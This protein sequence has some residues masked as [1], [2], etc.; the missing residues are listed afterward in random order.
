MAKR[1]LAWPVALPL[2]VLSALAGHSAGYRV[3]VPDA[4]ERQHLLE[5]TGHGYLAYA[6]AAVGVTL[7]LA[8]LGF[9]AIVVAAVRQ[10]RDR[11][12]RTPAWLVALLPPLGFVLQEHVERYGRHGVVE[13]ATAAEPA[14]LVGLALQF[15]FALVAALVAHALDRLAERVG[16]LIATRSAPPF[17]VPLPSLALPVSPTPP[18]A[19]VLARGYA[20]RAPPALL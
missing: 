1:H 6:P 9:A 10:R 19:P 16:A 14:F 12:V 18:R 8:V 13:W 3:V 2:A 11:H 7:A 5:Q 15:P 17:A 4:H 20:G